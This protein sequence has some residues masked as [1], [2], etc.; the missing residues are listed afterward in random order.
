MSSTLMIYG[1]NGYVG[2]HVARAAG[3]LGVKAIV[4]GRHA[5]KLDR[6]ASETGLEPRA[7]G[8]D[9]PAVID[10]ALNKV[11]VVLNCAGPFKYTAERLVE[12]CL[13]SR[14]HYLDITGEIP[15]FEALQ[16]KDAQAKAR[17]VML[18]PGVGFRR[19]PDRLPCAAPEAKTA[20]RDPTKARVPI[21]RSRRSAAGH[22]ANGDRTAQL[23]RPRPPQ[24]RAG[25]SVNRGRDDSRSTSAPGRSTRFGS[26][27]A[28]CSPPT[29]AR[30]F[31]T[32]KI[33]SPLRQR[34]SVS[35]QSAG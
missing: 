33:T 9:D 25:A 29:T 30:A 3:S 18:L 35:S 7:F 16:A 2:E 19:R 15:V 26:R 23:R 13:R 32:S 14:A 22:A 8:L 34:C 28:T 17:G 24:R 1:A 12:G 6:I 20:D 4:A 11:A 21:R 27:G 31:P 10:S 5:A